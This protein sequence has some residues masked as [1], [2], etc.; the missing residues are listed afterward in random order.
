MGLNQILMLDS[1]PHAWFPAST[2]LIGDVT[3]QGRL[4]GPGMGGKEGE[5][6]TGG[7]FQKGL[8]KEGQKYPVEGPG[9][10]STLALGQR[11]NFRRQKSLEMPLQRSSE[12]LLILES[13][14]PGFKSQPCPIP[15]C[16]ILSRCAYLSV[17]LYP[18]L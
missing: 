3:S 15:L 12:V 18:Y 4:L 7:A 16:V 6:G 9:G 5:V 10:T 1:Q 8:L 14:K 2:P 11:P 13:E 17:S